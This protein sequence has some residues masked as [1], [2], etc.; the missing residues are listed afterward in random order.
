MVV[1]DAAVTLEGILT[2]FANADDAD[3][4]FAQLQLDRFAQAV[5]GIEKVDH[6]IGGILG[7]MDEQTLLLVTSDH[8]M[9]FP[10]VKGYAYHDSNHIP[11]A[12]RWPGGVKNPGRVI[13]DFVA[14]GGSVVAASRERKAATWRSPVRAEPPA[15]AAS[16][17]AAVWNTRKTGS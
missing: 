6:F 11:L 17:S 9:P 2:H 7:A 14:G 13:E 3:P 12:I 16:L 5:A 10:R 4:S 15:T 1:A 8:G